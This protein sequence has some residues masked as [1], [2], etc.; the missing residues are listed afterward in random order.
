MNIR[1]SQLCGEADV[2]SWEGTRLWS[3]L[4]PNLY[5]NNLNGSNK[6]SKQTL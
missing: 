6:G 1:W 3:K 4:I 2:W 5:N